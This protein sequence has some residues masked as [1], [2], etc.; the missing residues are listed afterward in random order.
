MAKHKIFTTLRGIIIVLD[1][2][3]PITLGVS[4]TALAAGGAYFGLDSLRKTLRPDIKESF[5]SDSLDF[6]LIH[7]DGIT[8]IG[9]EG[10]LTRTFTVDGQDYGLCSSDE[11]QILLKR[12]AAFFNSV[13]SKD[14]VSLR[15]ITRRVP[16]EISCDGTYENAYLQT[17]H[18]RWQS[19][20]KRT[21]RNQ[22][23]LVLTK[24]PS[25]S[26]VNILKKG[27]PLP[28]EKG[29]FDELCERVE[30]S[31][32]SF[33]VKPLL[34]HTGGH[35]QLLS[36]WASLVNG[37]ET[38][39]ASFTRHLAERLVGSSVEFDWKAGR[40]HF[41]DGVTKKVAAIV[42]IQ[43][44]GDESSSALFRDLSRLNGEITFLHHIQG[45]SK[46]NALDYLEREKTHVKG[47]KAAH[48][49][50]TA[51][52]VVQDEE[53]S[54]HGYQFSMILMEDTEEKLLSLIKEAKCL[55]LSY[56]T[57][58]IIE[59]QALEHI[60]RS[61]FPGN[62][63]FVRKTNLFSHNL[64]H[65][66]T[67]DKDAVGL[68]NSDWGLGPLRN[69][70]TI[71]GNCFPLNLHVSDKPKALGHNLVIAPTGT[72]KTTLIQHI[73]AGAL[74]HP[75][76]RV[77]LF[78]RFNGT[79]I[80][81]EAC[82]GQY[83]DIES[84]A[85]VQLN[86]FV[87]DDS[88]ASRSRLRRLLRLMS[89]LDT[90]DAMELNN[91]IDLLQGLPKDIRILKN[92]QNSL[93]ASK[94]ELST[95]LKEWSTGPYTHWFNGQKKGKAY[96]ALDLSSSRLVG[97]EMTQVLNE[98]QIVGPLTYY[99]M[100]RILSVIREEACPSWLLIDEIKA[101]LDIP[102]FKKYVLMLLRE[103][104]KLGGVVTL[105]FQSVSDIIES[106][107]SSVILGQCETLFLFPNPKASYEEYKL[108]NLTESEWDYIKGNNRTANKF[109]HTV[110][111][112]KPKESVILNIDLT[113]LGDH[114]K[115]YSSDNDLVA[116]VKELQKREGDQWV[117]AYLEV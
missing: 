43:Q 48:E 10:S 114:I 50:E 28:V 112:K 70:K 109:R 24:Y 12:R 15:I 89:G 98:E 18:D 9:Q 101:M 49:F 94:S 8:L 5:L 106:G 63:T 73:I 6:H 62:E 26:E 75:D 110:L 78:D 25:Y 54:L 13:V 99:L 23:Y 4:M 29:K 107:V 51:K 116:K 3:L 104:R 113:S 96:D 71:N 76:L 65:I 84:E 97:F 56:G 14:E 31:L 45:V 58:C 32:D 81:T 57:Q 83:V 95:K 69:F 41:D 21:Y 37:Q 102:Y 38:H 74:R 91:I 53:G 68:K 47:G 100:E 64:S 30:N 22:H 80:F 103:L 16:V 33:K 90:T 17:L 46:L 79:R 86:P 115:L 92:I 42:S 55:F 35:S 85:G 88:L 52:E 34:C 11:F 2:T 44:W 67:F 93:F 105:C 60:W 108:L 7:G 72:G 19:Q 39:L 87:V 111:V 59:K 20:F 1:L 61:Q 77:Y 82:G 117:D 40:I 27:T 36:F 66:L